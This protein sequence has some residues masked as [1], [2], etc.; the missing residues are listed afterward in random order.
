MFKLTQTS[1]LACI[2]VAFHLAATA[3][4]DQLFR[5]DLPSRAA[6]KNEALTTDINVDLAVADHVKA[7]EGTTAKT[8]SRSKTTWG[9]RWH[10]W[11]PPHVH[12]PHVHCSSCEHVS[13][14]AAARKAAKDAKDAKDAAARAAAAAAAKAAKDAKDAAD[15]AINGA[16]KVAKMA[17]HT[18][19]SLRDV[20]H[21]W[22][23]KCA[24]QHISDHNRFIRSHASQVAALAWDGPWDGCWDGHA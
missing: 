22:W 9:H 17:A 23:P 3:A 6:S 24:L 13:C 12:I 18:F 8:K 7:S 10:R 16:T 4:D 2:L 15:K 20:Y 11:S 19:G 14:E 1:I 21:K 5:A